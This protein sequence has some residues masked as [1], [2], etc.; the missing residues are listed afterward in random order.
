MIEATPPIELTGTAARWAGAVDVPARVV[1]ELRAA[2]TVITDAVEV[3]DAADVAVD[4]VP[5]PEAAVDEVLAAET[6]PLA[7]S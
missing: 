2:T 7:E 3:A 1:D 6:E 4:E 5:V